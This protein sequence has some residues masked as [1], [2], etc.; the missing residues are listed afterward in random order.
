[1]HNTVPVN[2]EILVKNYQHEYNNNSY[3]HNALLAYT[4]T[5]AQ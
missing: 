4:R 3:G 5:S 2:P 1:M